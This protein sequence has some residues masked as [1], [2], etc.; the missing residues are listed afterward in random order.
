[1]NQLSLLEE[2]PA[3]LAWLKGQ[4]A[5]TFSFD[6]DRILKDIM[7]LYLEGQ[8]FQVDATYSTGVMWQN[9]PQPEL[10]Y[11]INPQAEGVIKA[12]A[13]QLPLADNSV[14]SIMFDPPFMP[15]RSPNN[16]GKIKTR[17]TSFSSL[18][19][20]WLMYRDSMAEFLRVLQPGGYLVIK[21]QD[22]VSASK[23]H[24]SHWMVESF[25]MQLGYE[26]IDMFILGSKRV[27]ISSK[28]KR[29][30]HARKNHSFLIVFQRPK[31]KKVRR[32]I[33]SQPS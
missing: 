9:L 10:K 12:D 8:A 14:R 5:F 11:D 27:L 18:Q 29:Q 28:W 23:N 3:R 32:G 24:W 16:P 21:C 20:M 7:L 15:T 1:M 2:I 19:E 22:A 13:R 26:Q 4:V 17:F 31:A 30:Q 6:Q 33:D 25:A